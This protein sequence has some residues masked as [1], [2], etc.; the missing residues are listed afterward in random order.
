MHKKLRY[1]EKWLETYI[2]KAFSVAEFE[3]T[4]EVACTIKSF[5][6]AGISHSGNG[7]VFYLA[8]G[9][10]FHVSIKRMN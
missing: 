2:S 5:S 7:L 6:D 3:S 10:K 4:L 9:S 1:T 8:D